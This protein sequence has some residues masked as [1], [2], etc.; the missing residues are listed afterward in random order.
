MR[1]QQLPLGIGLKDDAR[2]DNFYCRPDSANAFALAAVAALLA[3]R[4]QF[5]CLWGGQGR[6]HLSQALCL[7]AGQLGLRAQYLG[8]ASLAAQELT[9]DSVESV[10]A[11]LEHLDLVCLDDVHCVAGQRHWES[12]LFHLFNRLRD[13]GVP[14]LMTS[15]ENPA[16]LAV[17]LPDLQSRLQWGLS[18]QLQPLS[19][20]DKLHLLQR[21]AEARGLQLG[22]EVA[23]YLI[24]RVARDPASLFNLLDRLDRAS[25]QEK[26]K[27]TIPFVRQ[28][29]EG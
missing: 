13:A 23:H 10:L 3:G 2:F 4:E 1:P 24:T 20:D 17:A 12:A 19:D 21:R 6:S 16:H 7:E 11:G 5:V 28:V 25:L 8:L 22:D 29:L 26:R 27:L 15:Q 14:L 9:A 18:C